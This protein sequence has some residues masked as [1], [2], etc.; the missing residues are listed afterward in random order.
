M[1]VWERNENILARECCL[2]GKLIIQ[3]PDFL[4]VSH[5][6]RNQHV[7]EKS[8]LRLKLNRVCT[9]I[10][11][12]LH[13]LAVLQTLANHFK[14]TNTWVKSLERVLTVLQTNILAY[15]RWYRHVWPWP[16]FWTHATYI[17]LRPQIRHVCIQFCIPQIKS[18]GKLVGALTH[19]PHLNVP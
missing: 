10:Q 7:P 15:S 9:Q 14:L 8:N 5:Q 2:S 4:T 3:F 18:D 6:R 17:F 12:R 1:G 19:N 16:P 13:T 11:V